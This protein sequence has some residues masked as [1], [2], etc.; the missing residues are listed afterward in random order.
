MQQTPW[1]AIEVTRQMRLVGGA[2]ADAGALSAGGRNLLEHQVAIA[3][4]VTAPDRILVLTA[5]SDETLLHLIGKHELREVSPFDFIT[6]MRQRSAE[7]VPVVLLRQYVPLRDAADLHK[8]LAL[9]PQHPTIVSASQ[10]PAGHLRHQ[11]LP[12]QTEPD[13]RCLAF[14]VR[15]ASQFSAAPGQE[16]HLL[17]VPWDSFAEYLRPQDEADVA[18][19]MKAWGG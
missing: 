13:Y 17:F 9:L 4:Q 11:P 14:E 19:R 6:L 3:R 18:A 5:Q 10:P 1:V 2:V 16:E 8:A 7:D 12:G 15:R